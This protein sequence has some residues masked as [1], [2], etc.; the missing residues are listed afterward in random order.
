MQVCLCSFDT[1]NLTSFA[2]SST[3]ARYDEPD[4]DF[5]SEDSSF[6]T[7]IMSSFLRAAVLST[8]KRTRQ[9]CPQIEWF[10]NFTTIHIL[11]N[12]PCS[13]QGNYVC[14]CLF[15]LRR[16]MFHIFLA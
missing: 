5:S 12:P 3:L 11:A 6:F 10:R 7:A 16:S 4:L 14:H 1:A 8:Q 9:Y 13:V 15:A 2:S